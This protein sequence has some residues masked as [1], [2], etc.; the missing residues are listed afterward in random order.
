MGIFDLKNVTIKK[1]ESFLDYIFGGCEVSLH[2][3]VDFTL[4]NGNQLNPNSLH[5]LGP[6]N[7]YI[8]SI[9]AVGSI[10]QNYDTDQKFP[11]YGFGAKLPN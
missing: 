5:F 10:L 9:R 8:N 2:V 7:S 4:S 3:N 6:N 1:K 11:V